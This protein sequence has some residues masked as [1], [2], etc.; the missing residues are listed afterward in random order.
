MLPQIRANV[1]LET[2][3]RGT[4]SYI[5]VLYSAL[6][7]NFKYIFARGIFQTGSQQILRTF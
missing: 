4:Y 7:Q 2:E 5:G 3:E 6:V 1:A